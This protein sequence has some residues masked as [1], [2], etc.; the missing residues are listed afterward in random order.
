MRIDKKASAV[1]MT[2]LNIRV[3]SILH[4]IVKSQNTTQASTDVPSLNLS[5]ANIYARFLRL[6]G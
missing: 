1:L 6:L 3:Y 5:L 2:A 4:L